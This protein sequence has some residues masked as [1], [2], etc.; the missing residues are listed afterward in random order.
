MYKIS[1][2]IDDKSSSLFS[3]SWKEALLLHKMF[4]TMVHMQDWT[5]PSCVNGPESH[6]DLLF[7]IYNEGSF[8]IVPDVHNEHLELETKMDVNPWD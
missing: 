6:T 1:I 4:V 8:S 2:N 7:D 5:R 3:D